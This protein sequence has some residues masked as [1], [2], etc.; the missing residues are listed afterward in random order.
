MRKKLAAAVSI[1]GALMAV[2]AGQG[3][4]MAAEGYG[5]P[6]YAAC[7]PAGA[8]GGFTETGWT[9]AK[10][11]VKLE[12]YVSDI[13]SDGHHV[14]V[15]FL[16]VNSYLK[17]KYWAWHSNYDG[18]DHTSRWNTTASDSEGLYYT[19]VQVATLEGSKI[20]SYCTDWANI[21]G[22]PPGAT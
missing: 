7:T 3:P 17:I 4:A 14:A 12:L 20:I 18:L 10:A 21:P 9:G 6:A 1:S 8:A 19:G 13:R 5:S 11:S 22:D 16:S 2:L 15:R